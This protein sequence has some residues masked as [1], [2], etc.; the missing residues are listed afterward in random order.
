MLRRHHQLDVPDKPAAVLTE[1]NT[2]RVTLGEKPLGSTLH[3]GSAAYV[4]REQG[5]FDAIERLLSCKV[6][7]NPSRPARGGST[8]ALRFGGKL[9]DRV[10]H[11]DP[12]GGMRDDH[13][14]IRPVGEALESLL[15]ATAF[16]LVFIGE[17]VLRGWVEPVD[18]RGSAWWVFLMPGVSYPPGTEPLWPRPRAA[19]GPVVADEA[20]QWM[21]SLGAFDREPAPADAEMNEREEPPRNG[22]TGAEQ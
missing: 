4:P 14:F 19:F 16:G 21:D 22:T 2:L 1:L 13:G 10:A 9:A 15:I 5:V 3:L 11:G 8:W 18:E 6:V 17:G 12:Q 7:E 20:Q